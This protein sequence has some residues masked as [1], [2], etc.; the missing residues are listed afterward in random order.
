MH[1]ENEHWISWNNFIGTL[2]IFITYF[3]LQI[4]GVIIGGWILLSLVEDL[5]L[6]GAVFSRSVWTDWCW[7]LAC[8]V[9]VSVSCPGKVCVK[10]DC[11]L[12]IMVWEAAD[13]VSFKGGKTG[14]SS[15]SLSGDFVSVL[16]PS[17]LYF[18][19]ITLGV[20]S[21]CVGI[22]YKLGLKLT[23]IKRLMKNC[24]WTELKKK[25]LHG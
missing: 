23:L 16:S 25:T 6:A 2:Q 18:T 22:F 4:M 3:D 11:S 20:S 24:F 5:R 8:S 21:D 15:S 13:L 9:W 19:S 14:A 1:K 12:F 7:G 17:L 10:D